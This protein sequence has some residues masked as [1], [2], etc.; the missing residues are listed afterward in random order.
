MSLQSEITRIKNAKSALKTSLESK[1]VTV[2]SDALIDEYPALVESIQA[3]E[4]FDYLDYVT[5]GSKNTVVL[6]DVDG[7]IKQLYG[8]QFQSNG[9]LTSVY[10]PSCS[11][12]G[13]SVYNTYYSGNKVTGATFYNCSRL[14]SISLPAL[15]SIVGYGNFAYCSALETF[16]FPDTMSDM[17]TATFA[18]CTKLK[19]VTCKNATSA[20]YS[21]FRGCTNLKKVNCSTLKTIYASAFNACINLEWFDLSQ[22]TSIGSYAFYN[23]SNFIGPV[24]ANIGTVNASIFYG[25][26]I[27]ELNLTCTGGYS[28]AFTYCKNLSKVNLVTT[29]IGAFW[30]A[31]CSNL[32]EVSL[33]PYYNNSSIIIGSNAFYDCSN[34]SNISGTSYVYV[35]KYGAFDSCHKLESLYL[36]ICSAYYC[37]TSKCDE[38]REIYLPVVS[39]ISG[40]RHAFSECY[41]LQSIYVMQESGLT[42]APALSIASIDYAFYR[43][44]I[45]TPDGHPWFYV[46]Y[47]DYL[48][49]IQ[50]ATNWAYKSSWIKVSQYVPPTET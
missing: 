16:S 38:L 29:D 21:T 25:A 27:T 45:S 48:S 42:S 4:E 9:A 13:V 31:D 1:G 23:C 32:T 49:M 7:K 40:N 37:N 12:I 44:G 2:P 20:L 6:N 30:F 10:L 26:G 11:A 14:S 22:C 39:I 3:G 19:E 46:G 34:L 36:P 50:T 15:K 17:G 41:N 33:S 28:S 18:G 47:E 43:A 5:G 8:I 24:S 35:V